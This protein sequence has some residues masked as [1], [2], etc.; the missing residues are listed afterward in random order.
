[1]PIVAQVRQCP[2][3]AIDALTHRR[4]RQ[5]DKDRLGQADRGIDLDLNGNPLDT[6]QGER[7]EL[8]EH[9][10][11][12]RTKG[13]GLFSCNRERDRPQPCSLPG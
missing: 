11:G 8:G 5:A 10:G 4:F 7:V 13:H 9:A 12:L 3:D 6:D 1:V 2:L